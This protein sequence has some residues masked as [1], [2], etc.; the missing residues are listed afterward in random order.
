MVVV[1]KLCQCA[2]RIF[3][4]VGYLFAEFVFF[5]EFFPYDLNSVIGV[6]V[7]FSKD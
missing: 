3:C 7:G 6:A 5:A 2:F 4:V 1:A